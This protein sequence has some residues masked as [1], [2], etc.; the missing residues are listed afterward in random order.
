[1]EWFR[2]NGRQ[3]IILIVRLIKVVL[4]ETEYHE[5]SCIEDDTKKSQ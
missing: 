1:M 4:G 5:R 2:K 3:L